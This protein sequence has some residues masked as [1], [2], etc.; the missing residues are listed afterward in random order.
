MQIHIFQ[1]SELIPLC[2]DYIQDIYLAGCII[3][4]VVD[5][6][7][8]GDDF[9]YTSGMPGFAFNGSDTGS[10]VCQLLYLIADGTDVI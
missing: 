9:S 7:V 5:I 3:R 8:F 6:K 2:V 10:H 1:C 4:S